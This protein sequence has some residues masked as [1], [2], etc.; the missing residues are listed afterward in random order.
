V[1]TAQAGKNARAAS[2]VGG[3]DEDEGKREQHAKLSRC[4]LLCQ[5]ESHGAVQQLRLREPGEE[6]DK[7]GREEARRPDPVPVPRKARSLAPATSHASP[8]P[9]LPQRSLLAVGAHREEELLSPSSWQSGK[10]EAKM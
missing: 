4:S 3:V 9:P 1:D 8:P 2:Q 5:G 10:T 7:K 6:L